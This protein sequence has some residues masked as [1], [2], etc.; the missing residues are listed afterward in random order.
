MKQYGKEIS[1]VW[2][3]FVIDAGTAITGEEYGAY[4]RRRWGG[5]AWTLHLRAKGAK[6][7]APFNNWQ[8]WPNSIKAHTLVALAS[9]Q[10]AMK[11]ALFEATYEQGL[12][13][14]DEGTLLRIAR[15]QGIPE[16]HVR[17][18]LASPEARDRLRRQCAT[19]TAAGIRGVP[20]YVVSGVGTR[21]YT[22]SG[23]VDPPVFL[24]VFE[25]CCA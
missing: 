6:L 19:A 16:A 12:N 18:Q 20:Y 2:K 3:P 14:S 9:D 8:T 7:G 17:R 15:E 24:D 1:V 23:A 11:H 22:L 4:N 25:R 13:I 5:D 10:G 21:R